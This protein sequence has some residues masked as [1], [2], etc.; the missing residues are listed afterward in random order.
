MADMK[1]SVLLTLNNRLSGGIK[2]AGQDVGRFASGAA[3]AFSRIDRAINGTVGR[4]ASLGGG[5]SLAMAAKGVIDLEKQM[6]R[7]GTQAG[8]SNQEIMKLKESLFE[9]SRESRIKI[10]PSQLIGAVNAI[11]ERT[12]DL[13][14]AQANLESIGMAIQASGAKGEAIGGLYAE[15]Q[16]MGLGAA[17]ALQAIDTLTLQGKTGAFTL[18]NL[19]ALGPRVINAYTAT[20]RTGTQ[21]L[22]EMGAAL[23]VIRMGTGSSEQAATSFEALVRNLTDPT[24]QKKIEELGVSVYDTTGQ[25]RSVVDLMADIAAAGGSLEELGVIFDSEAMRSFNTA[26]AEFKRTGSIESLGKFLEIQGNGQTIMEDSARNAQTLAAN[27][28]NLKTV[29]AEFADGHLAGPIGTLAD[30]LNE[31][32]PEQFAAW[33]TGLK[34]IAIALGSIKALGVVTQIA[35]LFRGGKMKAPAAGLGGPTGVIP[36]Y[37]VNM[38]MG[39]LTGTSS[40]LTGGGGAAAAGGIVKNKGFVKALARKKGPMGWLAKK[41]FPASVKVSG[42]ASRIATAKG[43]MGGLFRLG[44]QAGKFLGKAGGAPLM[45]GIS[46]IEMAA[47]AGSDKLNKKEKSEKI[48]G[49]A[50]GLAGWAL[51]AKVGAAIGTVIGPGVGT[52]IGGALGG[53]AG[54]LGGKIGGEK[55]GSWWGSAAGWRDSALSA[56]SQADAMLKKVL[57]APDYSQAGMTPQQLDPTPIEVVNNT[58]ITIDDSG[59]THRTQTYQGR[60]LVQTETGYH[61]RSLAHRLELR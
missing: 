57:S 36:V 37:V 33:K 9:V 24:K 54:W 55:M 48:G 43:P 13:D 61:P 19:A 44:G 18:E 11:I 17:E 10:D 25:F 22:T 34:G 20:G 58:E 32:S 7:L 39:G 30:K 1:A 5:L 38:G 27:L 29:A 45:A 23:Q 50:G 21:A 60:Q 26:L 14:F 46:A 53:V 3:S 31:V 59:V 49:S 6:V 4:L 51:G 28:G 41:A 42:W 2:T 40:G 12:G 52:A 47:A 16:K 56:S 8:V 15:F 35:S